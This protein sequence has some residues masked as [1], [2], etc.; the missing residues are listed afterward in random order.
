MNVSRLWR[1]EAMEM[2]RKRSAWKEE[3][4]GGFRFSVIQPDSTKDEAGR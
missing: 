1:E 3:V 2:K 4:L